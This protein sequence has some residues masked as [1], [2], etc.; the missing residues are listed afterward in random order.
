MNKDSIFKKNQTERTYLRENNKI[1]LFLDKIFNIIK[2]TIKYKQ[3][4]ERELSQIN[5]VNISLQKN[6]G[7]T[8]K[9]F[10]AEFL[11]QGRF[12]Q[13]F[14]KFETYIQKSNLT[15]LSFIFK[16]MHFQKFQK[17]NLITKRIQEQKSINKCLN[18][19][20]YSIFQILTEIFN[21]SK[22]YIHQ[23]RYI[24]SFSNQQINKQ[25]TL[26]FIGIKYF[27]K[28]IGINNIQNQF[29][30]FQSFEA[31]I[32]IQKF[33]CLNDKQKFEAIQYLKK[34]NSLKLTKKQK[35]NK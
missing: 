20:Y 11:K 13:V 6:I 1:K 18:I 34:N 29:S 3:V 31:I 10:Q 25:F 7:K 26:I 14:K 28:L 27:I 16:K 33:K 15:N 22:V 12:H 30:L 35:Q 17:D 4:I 19:F 5:Y 2:N 23:A 9:M 32:I 21:N 8:K 24:N